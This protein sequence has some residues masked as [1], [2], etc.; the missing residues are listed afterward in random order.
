MCI[1]NGT[2]PSPSSEE[3]DV[4]RVF[5]SPSTPVFL[6]SSGSTKET[7]RPLV[8]FVAEI[9]AVGIP[10]RRLLVGVP[11]NRYRRIHLIKMMWYLEAIPF[12]RKGSSILCTLDFLALSSRQSHTPYLVVITQWT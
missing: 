9:A 7:D 5:S 10:Q 6:L 3:S 2:I 11:A 8:P 4:D 12:T 1:E